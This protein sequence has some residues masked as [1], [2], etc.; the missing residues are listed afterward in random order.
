MESQR[1]FQQEFW[2]ENV[3]HSDAEYRTVVSLDTSWWGELT[4]IVKLMGLGVLSYYRNVNVCIIAVIIFCTL[5]KS[6]K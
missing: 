5:L 2:R 3:K 6:H 4:D 1:I